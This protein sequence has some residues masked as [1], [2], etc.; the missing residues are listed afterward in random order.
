MADF[1]ALRADLARLGLSAKSDGFITDDQGLET[2]DG[3]KVLTN[4][5]IERLCKVVRRPGGTVPNPNAGD[6]G[7]TATL[8]NPGEQ[9]PLLAELK[10]KLDWYYLR[11]KDQTSRVVGSPEINLVNVRGIRNHRDWEK[12]HMDV[13]SPE[14]SLQDWSRKIEIIEE[15]LRR[16][17]GVSKIPLAYVVRSEELMPAA[18]PVGGYQSLQD[19]LIARAPIWVGNT[20]NTAYTADYLADRSK[21]WELISDITRDQDWWLYVRPSQLTRYERLAFLGLNNHYLGENNFDNMSSRA[22]AKLKNTC[23]SG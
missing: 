16:C 18:T 21:V 15:W 1:V 4:D 20:G 11:L 5:E 6:P 19:E 13:D 9:V 12:S 22:E 14:L 3:L 2:L 7:Q 23:Y 17:L 8:S 10:L